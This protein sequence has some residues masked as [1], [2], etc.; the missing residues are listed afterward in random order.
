MNL[1]DLKATLSIDKDSL[2]KATSNVKKAMSQAGD[3]A[4]KSLDEGITDGA[5]KGASNAE[6]EIKNSVG[7]IKTT[8]G[9]FKSFMAKVFGV[10]AAIELGKQILTL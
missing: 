9:E 7:R 8:F 6:K 10:T 3:D 5:K 4:G 1:G 2:N